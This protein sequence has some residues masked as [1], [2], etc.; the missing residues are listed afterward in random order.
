MVEGNERTHRL[1]YF[2]VTVL[3]GD[4]FVPFAPIPRQIVNVLHP[5]IRELSGMQIYKLNTKEARLPWNMFLETPQ[6]LSTNGHNLMEAFW[7]V[8]K[9][10]PM[11]PRFERDIRLCFDWVAEAKMIKDGD[12]A[13][14]LLLDA[15]KRKV[16][17][18][19]L[20][21]HEMLVLFLLA[22]THEARDH[23]VITEGPR[24]RDCTAAQENLLKERLL[25]A[26]SNV[27][28][29]VVSPDR[30]S[31]RIDTQWC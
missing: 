22:L 4:S 20:S 29:I 12:N 5:T 17:L 18:S 8:H 26:S 25:E 31:F 13:E 9:N 6:P 1:S 16:P 7:D 10:S 28:M 21:D 24:W 11:W 27:Q 14:L 2:D 19:A 30:P 3:S 23:L 15:D